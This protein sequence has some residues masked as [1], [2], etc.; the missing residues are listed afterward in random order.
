MRLGYERR[1]IQHDLSPKEI[2]DVRRQVHQLDQIGIC[3][4]GEPNHAIELE[5]GKASP[6]P[7]GGFQHVF[8]RNALED[9]AAQPLRPRLRGDGD[10]ATARGFQRLDQALGQR[11]HA[12]RGYRERCTHRPQASG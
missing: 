5:R 4:C 3:L 6:E 2:P 1:H 8:G 11:A 10:R 9:Q 12:K 7:A